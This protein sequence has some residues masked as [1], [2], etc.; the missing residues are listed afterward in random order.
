MLLPVDYSEYYFQEINPNTLFMNNST[1]FPVCQ[2][3]YNEDI[4]IVSYS[5]LVIL[6]LHINV[7]F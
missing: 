2:H 7:Y 3:E 1:F 4:I 5:Y 6:Q